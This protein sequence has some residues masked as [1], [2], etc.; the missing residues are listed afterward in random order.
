M[1]GG[2]GIGTAPA[3]IAV[4]N[5][6]VPPHTVAQAAAKPEFGPGMLKLRIAYPAVV[7]FQLVILI[8]DPAQVPG[9]ASSIIKDQS[10]AGGTMLDAGGTVTAILNAQPQTI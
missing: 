6:L 9:L 4:P 8:A 2:T 3:R 1:N 7:N 5:L 10:P